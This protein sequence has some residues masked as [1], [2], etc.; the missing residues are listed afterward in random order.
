M[1]YNWRYFGIGQDEYEK[2][3]KKTFPDNIYSLQKANILV[4]TLAFIYVIARY[5]ID[6]N[7]PVSMAR[8]MSVYFATGLIALIQIF[9]INHKIKQVNK[10]KPVS[11][12]LIYALIIIYFVNVIFFGIYLGIWANPGKI[13]GA[14]LGILIC[15]LFIFDIPAIFSMSLTVSAAIIFM[16]LTRIATRNG[17]PVKAHGDWFIDWSNAVFAGVIGIYFGW[18]IVKSRIGKSLHSSEAEAANKAKSVFLANMSHEIRTPMNS[19]IGFTELAMYDNLMPKTRDYLIKIQKNSEWLMQLINDILDIS[20]IES[21]RMEIE[22]IPFN[23]HEILAACRTMIMPKAVEK[24]LTMHFYAEPSVGKRLYGDPIKLHQVLVNLLSNAVK[25]TNTGMIKM[26]GTIKNISADKVTMYFEIIDSGIG[27]TADQMKKLF[28][29]FTQA[30]AGTTRKFGGSGLG[31]VI[32][33]NLI[34]MMGGKLCV[35]TTPGLGSK[36]SFE[37]TFDAVD[38]ADETNPSERILFDNNLEKPIFEGEVLV[39]EDNAM[40]QQV[41]CEHLAQVGIKTEVA[42][43]GEQGVAIVQKRAQKIFE[44]SDKNKPANIKQFDLI[45]MDIHMPVMDGIEATEKIIAID[46]NIPIVAMTANVITDDRDI[47]LSTGMRECVSKPFTSQVLWR[48]LLKFL[49]PVKWEKER[50]LE[51]EHASNELYQ[52]LINLFVKNNREKFKEIKNA[53]SIGDIELAHRLAHTLKGNAGQLNKAPLA[54]AASEVETSL[55]NGVNLVTFAQM[56][57][58]KAE[59]NNTIEELEPL[60]QIKE[61]PVVTGV[62]DDASARDLLDKLEL[63]LKNGNPE[64]LT[65]VND[66]GMI[67]GSDELI[68]QMDDFE[69]NEALKTL[70]VLKKKYFT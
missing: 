17:I 28:T 41:I 40:N 12:Q 11:N 50:M 53:M 25:F 24:N 1:L 43:N 70:A 13:A 64:C 32:T 46:A 44:A 65:F 58:L 66:L 57:T 14:F 6:S 21:G 35:E 54:K 30:E 69:F 61:K 10:K 49:N 31:L 62:L 48:C 34:E 36:F 37:L 68:N 8:N 16:I 56:E 55:K 67:Q 22:N 59:L 27:I 7:D 42:N 52:E 20:K 3:L 18:H 33:K 29:P 4:A 2:C 51:H 15:A 39:C 60:V 45:F 9:F 5:F 26:L 38:V 19:I 23:P 47:Y 63:M